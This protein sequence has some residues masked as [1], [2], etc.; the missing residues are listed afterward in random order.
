MK[1]TIS[2]RGRVWESV[3]K[4]ITMRGYVCYQWMNEERTEWTIGAEP[5]PPNTVRFRLIYDREGNSSDDAIILRGF[6]RIADRLDELAATSP[7]GTIQRPAA[8]SP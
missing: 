3:R 1:R 2:A 7:A 5:S 8:P 6:Q 4:S